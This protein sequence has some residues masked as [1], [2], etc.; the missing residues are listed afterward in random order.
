MAEVATLKHGLYISTDAPAYMALAAEGRIR[1][2]LEEMVR[3]KRH[4]LETSARPE[5]SNYPGTDVAMWDVVLTSDSGKQLGTIERVEREEEGR[6]RRERMRRDEE[7]RARE[8]EREEERERRERMGE[9]PLPDDDEE[10]LVADAGGEK[11]SM[12]GVVEDP[13]TT[14]T[15]ATPSGQPPS[16][17]VQPSTDG[18]PPKKKKK[19]TTSLPG[20]TSTTDGTTTPSTSTPKP[21]KPKKSTVKGI[22]EQAQKRVS[23]SVALQ[24]AGIARKSWML[25]GGTGGMGSP[26]PAARPGQKKKDEGG[27]V[28]SPLANVESNSTDPPSATGGAAGGGWAKPFLSSSTSTPLLPPTPTNGLSSSSHPFA[29]NPLSSSQPEESKVSLQDALW[30][31][32]K[33]VLLGPGG[34]SRAGVNRVVRKVMLGVEGFGVGGT[35]VGVAAFGGGGGVGEVRK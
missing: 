30:V 25:G 31:L 15:G 17:P 29:F 19:T 6:R 27:S 3:A 10:D 23:N 12:E 8:R 28:G 35:K 34:R 21:P 24:S 32:E 14:S 2:L 9:P 18:Q 4:R 1:G 16:S 20:T 7:A 13:S 5:P 33:E 26:S 22:S 11:D